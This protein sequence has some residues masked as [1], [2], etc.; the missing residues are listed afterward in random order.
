MS[1]KIFGLFVIVS[2]LI[3]T[4]LGT[5][6]VAA[7]QPADQAK[8][9]YPQ[10]GE[11]VWGRVNI[12]GTAS[13]ANADSFRYYQVEYSYDP[14]NAPWMRID[15]GWRARTTQRLATWDTTTLY[16]GQYTLRLTVV[17]I[18]GN[19]IRSEL[20]TVVVDNGP[21]APY[22]PELV[23]ITSPADGATIRG[24]SNIV[25]TATAYDPRQCIERV[26]HADKQ[27]RLL[28]TNIM[29]TVTADDPVL[30]FSYYKVEY[31]VG[32][33]PS[34]WHLVSELDWRNY[35]AR[36]R[37]RLDRWDTTLVPNGQY[38]LRLTVVDPQG[39]FRQDQVRV[40]VNNPPLP[41]ESVAKITWPADE[42]AIQRRETIKGT[43]FLAGPD[44]SFGSFVL[45]Y[46]MG[47][48]PATW[49]EITT[50]TSPKVDERLATWK[51]ADLPNGWYTL[52]LTV[53]DASGEHVLRD[54]VKVQIDNPPPPTVSKAEITSPEDG[55]VVERRVGIEGTAA[56]AVQDYD[57]DSFT[58]EHDRGTDPSSCLPPWTRIRSRS[59]PIVDGWLGRW[60]VTDLPN[61]PYTL[62]LTVRDKSGEFVLRDQV[63]VQVENPPPPTESK[64]EITD[65]REGAVV[66]GRVGI[67]GTAALAAQEYEFG[68]FTLEY[69][70]GTE[71]TSWTRIRSRSYPM[72]DEWLAPWDVASLPNGPY[73]LRL[74]VRDKSGEFVLQDLITVTVSNPPA[75]PTTGE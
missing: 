55:A 9:T 30:G 49:T 40:T 57:F 69:G 18:T 26:L 53:Q 28:G 67:E 39:N 58:L 44:Q 71:P 68:S 22:L 4:F 19:F 73:T 27:C 62:R 64:A 1:R 63:V 36:F 24:R 25:G 43:A 14:D 54:Q 41:T 42:T 35:R 66:K 11:V 72:V 47:A 74:T 23:E 6:P 32:Y 59:Y 61:G 34:E 46:G 29:K 13:L 60:D 38:T 70:A 15:R 2:I 5:V 31:G 48:N 37:S 8:I 16:N 10:N 56:L 33:E 75:T 51:I 3:P 52:R 45:E 50:G 12:F 20:V 65:P 21:C 7:Q 17:D